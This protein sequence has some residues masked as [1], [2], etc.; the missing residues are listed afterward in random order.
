MR[1]ITVTIFILT[2]SKVISQLNV[3]QDCKKTIWPLFNESQIDKLNIEG[4]VLETIQLKNNTDTTLYCKTIY[5][6]NNSRILRIEYPV[7]HKLNPLWMNFYYDSLGNLNYIVT[8][9]RDNRIDTLKS[10]EKNITNTNSPI[11]KPEAGFTYEKEIFDTKGN[12]VKIIYRDDS[13]EY[14][15]NKYDNQNRKIQTDYIIDDIVVTKTTYSY[16]L[17][18]NMIYKEEIN[19]TNQSKNYEKNEYS[20]NGFLL[21]SYGE[22]YGE[23]WEM[24]FEKINCE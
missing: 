24:T 13:T 14:I 12:V 8:L 6:E 23:Y 1:F 9:T 4:K 22:T 20:S 11:A 15:I 3:P 2:F 16:D 10:N 17:K 21:K 19:L 18:G 5:D 7:S